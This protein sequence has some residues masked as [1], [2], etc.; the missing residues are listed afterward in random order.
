MTNENEIKNIIKES[1]SEILEEKYRSPKP[2]VVDILGVVLTPIVIAAVS[3]FVTIKME[4][5]QAANAKLIADS[6]I[7][8]AQRMAAAQREHS[9]KLT[10]AELEV[11]R[12]IQIEEVFSKVIEN[13]L[14]SAD[15]Q[16]KKRLIE[17]KK[18]LIGSLTV[19]RETSLPFLVR[20][21][22]YFKASKGDFQE[23]S[24]YANK[25]IAAVLSNRH[26]NIGKLDFSIEKEL[27]ILRFANLVEYNLNG[28]VFDN[29]NL[30]QA[31]FLRSSLI[32]ASF[33]NADLVGA[34]FSETKL[35]GAKFNGADLKQAEFTGSKLESVDFENAVNLE[36]ARF[37]LF[38]I[39]KT[40]E[41]KNKNPFR[42][43]KVDN[44]T[45]LELLVQH[46]E[47]LD[48]INP[49]NKRLNEFLKRFDGISSYDDL[50][51]TLEKREAQRM[52]LKD[53]ESILLA[54][55]DHS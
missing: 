5:T 34:D 49:S 7:K 24:V 20:I 48:K 26:L 27:R 13:G 30:F 6:Q 1:V 19:H 10:Q 18:M 42:E 33:K 11:Q 39:L 45:V 25:T 15:A 46:I 17:T 14:D 44:H 23:L 50:M 22:D 41:D 12:L 35:E 8:S 40:Y 9:A 43:K 21:R 28:V 53:S 2:K 32:G 37:S 3:L 47:E 29:C 38:S 54:A 4:E 52:A 16:A 31:K 51:E 55:A 36:Y